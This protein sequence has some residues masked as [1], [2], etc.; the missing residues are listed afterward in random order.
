MTLQHLV[1]R[2]IRL[3]D[4]A[5]RKGKQNSCCGCKI[6]VARSNRM[7]YRNWENLLDERN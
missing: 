4:P 7:I 5:K 2:M 3:S 6:S 1:S